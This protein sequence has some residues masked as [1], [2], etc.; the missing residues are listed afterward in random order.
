MLN[1]MK[2]FVKTVMPERSLLRR[3]ARTRFGGDVQNLESRQLLAAH[4]LKHHVEAAEVSVEKAKP[5]AATPGNFSGSWDFTTSEFNGVVVVNQDGKRATAQITIEDL[6]PASVNAKIKGNSFVARGQFP[7]PV[8]GIGNVNAKIKL[9]G[10]LDGADAFHGTIAGKASG[11]K[12]TINY[13]AT[14]QV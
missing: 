1:A 4:V 5:A 6:S 8:P 3:R 10:T 9:T 13:T 11:Q 14:R 7:V 2:E 12:L